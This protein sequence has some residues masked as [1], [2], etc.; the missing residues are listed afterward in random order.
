[1]RNS[2]WSFDLKKKF[3]SEVV[4]EITVRTIN[5][6]QHHL[7]VLFTQ[8]FVDDK[9]EWNVKGQPKKGYKVINGK[10]VIGLD[11]LSM[12]KVRG[13]KPSSV[14]KKLNN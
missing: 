7:D 11:L 4:E 9:L 14:K 6:Q 8:P 10:N 13:R 3:I 1:M 2:N 5:K 12:D